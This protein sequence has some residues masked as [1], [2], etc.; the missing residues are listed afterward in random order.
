MFI[1]PPGS[2]KSTVFDAF[3]ELCICYTNP[4]NFSSQFG[5]QQII[6]CRLVMCDEPKKLEDDK[7]EAKLLTAGQVSESDIKFRD[8]K[9]SKYPPV[10]ICCN[11]SPFEEDPDGAF[12]ARVK[13]YHVKQLLA[14]NK[15]DDNCAFHPWRIKLLFEELGI[16]VAPKDKDDEAEE[17]IYF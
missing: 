12:A 14:K 11:K 13:V 15:I 5:K 1:G 8:A 7:E 10:I 3:A 16:W 4:R 17:N 2:G 6:G 9:R